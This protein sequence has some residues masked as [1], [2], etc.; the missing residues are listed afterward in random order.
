MSTSGSTSRTASGCTPFNSAGRPV[1]DELPSSDDLRGFLKSLTEHEV[2][3]LVLGGYAVALH[4]Y[5]RATADFDL[6]IESSAANAERVLAAL[7]HFGFT[8]TEEAAQA[9][10]T[11]GK[12][13]RLGYPPTRIELLTAPAGVEFGPCRA[14]AVMKDLFGVA[15][16]VIGLDDLIANKR[17][18]GRPKDLIDAAELERIRDRRQA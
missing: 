1:L 6:W 3:F 7:R 14:R 9:L 10:L 16:P 18:A 5:P 11:P 4:G 17:A 8:P 12:I 2:A 13:L 15:V